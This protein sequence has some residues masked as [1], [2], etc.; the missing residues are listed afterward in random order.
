MGRIKDC[1][2]VQQWV[3]LNSLCDG[4]CLWYG[5]YISSSSSGGGGFLL[6]VLYL[7]LALLLQLFSLLVTLL[8]G[9]LSHLHCVFSDGPL[10]SL[11]FLVLW[12][13][14]FTVVF[15]VFF[16]SSV[17]HIFLTL[18]FILRRVTRRSLSYFFFLK[19]VF[20]RI[21]EDL[22]SRKWIFCSV[23]R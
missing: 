22:V 1:W 7:L 9:P 8:V 14:M 6:L 20:P 10:C 17:N 15:V 3:W 23:A 18:P 11:I 13:S 2:I 21:L 16:F 4:F 12:C 5:S 19:K